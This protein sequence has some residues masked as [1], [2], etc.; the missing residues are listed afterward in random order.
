[1]RHGDDDGPVDAGE[2][3][4]GEAS[5]LRPEEEGKLVRLRERGVAQGNRT[6]VEGHGNA[7]EAMG[8]Q[9]SNTPPAQGSGA[10]AQGTWK[11]VP[12]ETRIDRRES[13][14]AQV[15]AKRTP[16]TPNAAAD[17]KSAPMLDTSTSP[18]TT[19]MREEL[20]R[21]SSALAGRGRSTQ[22]R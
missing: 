2:D 16:S 14:S 19:A 12:I 11:T 9:R 5:A 1:M 6:V 18:S 3:L 7:L 13:G 15:G 4:F 17:L 21:M 8:P 22:A 10:G 20:E